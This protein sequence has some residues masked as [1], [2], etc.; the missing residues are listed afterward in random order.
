LGSKVQGTGFTLLGKAVNQDL[1][2]G[3]AVLGAFLGFFLFARIAA[4]VG[5]GISLIA[6]VVCTAFTAYVLL[7]DDLAL[8]LSVLGILVLTPLFVA[9]VFLRNK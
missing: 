7:V 3:G 4:A 6:G 8:G 5:P 9:S 1:R 2:Y